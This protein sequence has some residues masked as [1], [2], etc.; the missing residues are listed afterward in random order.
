[1]PANAVAAATV[2]DRVCWLA[3]PAYSRVNPLLPRYWA[4][5]PI[6]VGAGLPAKRPYRPSKPRACI[7]LPPPPSPAKP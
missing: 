7:R 2:Y 6:D 3:G 5:P 4:T 1:M